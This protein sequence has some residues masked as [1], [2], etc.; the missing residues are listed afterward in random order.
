MSH[1]D[2]VLEQ[3]VIRNYLSRH[4]LPLYYSKPVLSHIETYIIMQQR[5]GF[6]ER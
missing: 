1:T 5:K 6:E 3:T 2:I 4:R